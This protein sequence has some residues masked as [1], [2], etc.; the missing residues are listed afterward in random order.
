[1]KKLFLASFVFETGGIE[2]KD[3]QLILVTNKDV[4]RSKDKQIS[5]NPAARTHDLD[6]YDAAYDVFHDWFKGAYPE[7]ELKH[8][9]CNRPIQSSE[10]ETP[11]SESSLS[12]SMEGAD[13]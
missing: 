8:I 2:Y 10:T 13:I 5:L 7:S 12:G 9:I 11:H 1:M 3:R 6:H 4:E